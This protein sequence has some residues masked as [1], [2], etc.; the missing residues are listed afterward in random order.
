LKA[1]QTVSRGFLRS[2]FQS[3]RRHTS[4]GLY[5]PEL[6]GLRC[7]AIM[8]VYL[9]H[10]AG[11]VL[12]HTP[13]E[14][15]HSTSFLFRLTQQLNVGVPLFF[16]ISG[17]ILGLPFARQW[18]QDGPRVSL[19]RYLLRRVTRLEPPYV[20]ALLLFFTLK[21]LAHRDQMGH[22]LPH[23]GASIL[24]LHNLIYG[25]PSPINFVAWSLEI[26][27][28]F[29]LMAPAL[30]LVFAL[31]HKWVRRPVIA[32]AVVGMTLLARRLGPL[33]H[34]TL[35]GNIQYFLA[36]FL[37]AE[38]FLDA[39]PTAHRDRLWDIASLVGWPLMAVMLVNFP[40][41]ADVALPI[42]IPLLYLAALY[43]PSSS[44]A[45]ASL[46]A[47]AIGG[48]CYT[49]YLLH[50][51]ILTA[52]GMVTEG[53]TLG[54][55]FELRLFVQLLLVSPIVL[56]VCVSFYRLIEQP[57][58]RPDWTQRLKRI[59]RPRFVSAGSPVSENIEA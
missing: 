22:L 54:G 46:W 47:T 53:I 5:I 34:L 10:L 1:V 35:A 16:V 56:A 59:F 40:A 32:L 19:G 49:I 8:S 42:L 20:V 29:Y 11:D 39:A 21:V 27:V 41:A 24:Y 28:Q 23:L 17:M 13:P 4:S 38:V 18:I 58:M 43:G 37:L 6:D 25:V 52:A 9:Y 30:A 7:V 36:G 33:A 55:S 45:F 15:P 3:L 51:Y 50:N 14:I 57:C 31:R 2:Q 48:M 12:R 44:A 26:E